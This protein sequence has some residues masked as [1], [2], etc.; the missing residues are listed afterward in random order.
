MSPFE[1]GVGGGVRRGLWSRRL[2]ALC[3][4]LASCA[5]PTAKVDRDSSL[6]SLEGWIHA[7]VNAH[8]VSSGLVPL[9]YDPSV[10]D[11]A[12][13]H[14][15]SMAAHRTGVGHKD[16][17]ARAKAISGILNSSGFAENVSRH[18]RSDRRD[19]EIAEAAMALWLPSQVHRKNL[20]GRYDVTGVGVVRSA[21]GTL[22]VTQIF[23]RQ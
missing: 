9:G 12:R 19:A 20:E 18:H 6:H 8:R 16:F 3:L 17:A 14:S 5:A 2:A 13:G 11:I 23:V 22:Y 10:A 4:A 21:D 15:R 7:A 1:V